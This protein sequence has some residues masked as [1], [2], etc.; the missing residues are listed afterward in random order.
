[1]LPYLSLIV[2][3]R[4]TFIPFDSV[5]LKIFIRYTSG[6]LVIYNKNEMTYS[7]HTYTTTYI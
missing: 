6:D 4:R 5:D 3:T 1:M 2:R 7:F